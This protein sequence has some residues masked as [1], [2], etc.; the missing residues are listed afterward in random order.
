[1]NNI[2]IIPAV[3]VALILLGAAAIQAESMTFD[4][5]QWATGDMNAQSP[6]DSSGGISNSHV[7]YFYYYERLPMNMAVIDDSLAAGSSS[8]TYDSAL[9]MLVVAAD[10]LAGTDSMRIFGRRLSRPWSEYGVSWNYHH[11]SP[12]SAWNT[13]G[14]DINNLSCMDT[15]IIDTAI[16]TGDTL[17]FHLDTG[18]VR[19]MIEGDNYGWLMM[20][21]NLV[22][23]ATLQFYTEDIATPAYR[24]VLKVFYTEGAQ[25]SDFVG[26]RRRLT[27]QIKEVIK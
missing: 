13:A 25:V 10:G 12:D 4:Q 18:F 9:L 23:R 14:G 19:E 21:E 26:R 8:R 27:A 5:S 1:M 11:A 15:I 6:A 3:I 17:R 7:D 2:R 20:A 22:D 24:P 16:T